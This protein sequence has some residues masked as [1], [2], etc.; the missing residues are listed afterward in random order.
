MDKIIV[1]KKGVGEYRDDYFE[2][3]IHV[4][5]VDTEKEVNTLKEEYHIEVKK[6]KLNPASE[7]T[8]MDYIQEF[9][10]YREL[11]FSEVVD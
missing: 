7:Y 8:F 11:E 4:V 5:S 1:I 3:V 9:Y 6:R 2:K 10:R